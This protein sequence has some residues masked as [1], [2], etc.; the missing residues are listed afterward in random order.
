MPLPRLFP[1]SAS[2][3]VA[4][5]SLSPSHSLCLGIVKDITGGYIIKYHA[6]GYDQPPIEIDFTPPFRRISM[7]SGLEDAINEENIKNGG[8]GKTRRRER[9]RQ[10]NH[11]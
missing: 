1:A 4:Y 10:A 6:N 9:E 2:V 5:L 3:S 7:I 11:V 8:K